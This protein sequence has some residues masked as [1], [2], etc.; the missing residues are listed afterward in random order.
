MK[1][2]DEK[3]YVFGIKAKKDENIHTSVFIPILSKERRKIRVFV[4]QLSKEQKNA[5]IP[6]LLKNRRKLNVFP[7]QLSKE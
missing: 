2:E 7:P 4:T 1:N 5:F 6:Q 3:I